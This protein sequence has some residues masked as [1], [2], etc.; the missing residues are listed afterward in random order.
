VVRDGLLRRASSGTVVTVLRAP[1]STLGDSKTAE[2]FR[3][4]VLFLVLCVEFVCWAMPTARLVPTGIDSI[5][6]G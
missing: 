6:T 4:G 3:C 5:N 1:T 2:E